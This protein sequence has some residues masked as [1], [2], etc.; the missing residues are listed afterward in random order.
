M[1]RRRS[2]QVGHGDRPGLADRRW[3]VVP[4]AGTAN[5]TL[6]NGEVLTGPKPVHDGDVLARLDPKRDI[7][8]RATSGSWS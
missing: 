7:M 4:M 3:Q 1:Y 8:N 5:E 2:A 6:L